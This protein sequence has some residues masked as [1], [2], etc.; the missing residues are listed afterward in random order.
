MATSVGAL[1][2]AR[3]NFINRCTKATGVATGAQAG[4]DVELEGAIGEQREGLRKLP[5]RGEP[6]GGLFE[7][8]PGGA[9]ERPPVNSTVASF[10]FLRIDSP[11]ISMR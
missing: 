4:V 9:H 10:F 7:D 2:I 1:V 3:A 6:S 5:S 8:Q 11:F